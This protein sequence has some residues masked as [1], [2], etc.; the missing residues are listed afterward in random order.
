MKKLLLY[1]FW[2]FPLITGA[3]NLL[4]EFESL[5]SIAATSPTM[6]NI[7][8]F[9]GSELSLETDGTNKFVKM[10]GATQQKDLR[11]I[12]SFKAGVTYRLSA[13][14]KVSTVPSAEPFNLNTF[15]NG[16]TVGFNGTLQALF[17]AGSSSIPTATVSADFITL[18]VAGSQLT[19]EYKESYGSLLSP[20]DQ[21][22]YLRFL[23]NNNSSAGNT[24]YFYDTIELKVLDC[25]DETIELTPTGTS[26]KNI[27]AND[28]NNGAAIAVGTNA[29]LSGVTFYEADGVTNAN[30]KFTLNPDGTITSVGGVAETDYKIKYTLTSTADA[31]GSG[32]NDTDSIT[33]TF[34]VVTTLGVSQLEKSSFSFYPNPTNSVINVSSEQD[35]TTISLFNLL[36]QE[37]LSKSVNAKQYTLNVDSLS[38]GTYLM[39]VVSENTAEFEKVVIQ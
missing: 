17:I 21:N 30:A 16:R 9:N 38:K 20:T 31:D 1:C 33:Q 36:G 22:I 15:F 12:Y 24:T 39:K 7:W 29:N 13:K 19:T 6:P 26:I 27:F 34:K 35:I 5:S 25:A 14:V 32:T 8:G 3:Q 2:S 28:I 4:P 11:I 23:R 10:L 37:V 18:Q